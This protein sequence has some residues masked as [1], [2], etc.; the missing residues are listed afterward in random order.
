[1]MKKV[2][3][4]I[5]FWLLAF[6]IATGFMVYQRLTGPTYE[7]RGDFEIAGNSYAYDFERSHELAPDENG[8][9]DHTVTVAVADTTVSGMLFWKRLGVDEPYT[10]VEMERNGDILSGQLPHQPEAGKLVYH[11]TLTAGDESVDLPSSDETVTIRFK[12]AVPLEVLLPHILAMVIVMI[13][14]V[15][16]A[17]AALA[18]EPLKPYA[19]ASLIVLLIGGFVLGPLVQKYAFDDWWTGWPF[20]DDLTD[21]K[22]LAAAI[23]WIIAL[24]QIR[25]QKDDRRS[26]WWVLGA[27]IVVL[28]VYT[29]PHSMGGST[30]DY[31]T[32]QITTGMRGSETEAVRDTTRM[33]E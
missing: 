4:S 33:A 23:A 15:R 19:W 20:G 30:F 14:S 2:L 18:G 17:I 7:L 22:T 29:I 3:R 6:V 5:L 32:G 8:S 21:N 11:V 27:A 16:A 25:R 1:M 13:L 31:E 28:A 9:L 26:R 24:I 10:T 12:G